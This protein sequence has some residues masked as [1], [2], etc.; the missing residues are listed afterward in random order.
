MNAQIIPPYLLTAIVVSP[1][2]YGYVGNL[3]PDTTAAPA[4]ALTTP[5]VP[6]TS[7]IDVRTLAPYGVPRLEAGCAQGSLSRECCPPNWG[8]A[9][10]YSPGMCPSAYHAYP[11][12]TSKQ[13]QET[14]NFCCPG[15]ETISTRRTQDYVQATP[16]QIRF[17]ASE[18]DIVPVPTSSLS[19]PR[20]WLRT[21]EKVG[22]GI[23]VAAGVGLISLALYYFFWVRRRGRKQIPQQAIPCIHEG[24]NADQVPPPP[25]AGN[26]NT[27][28][29]Q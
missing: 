21:R 29:K 22:I 16:I 20:D 28:T 14:T 23:G 19:L 8:D 2:A 9:V 17:R 26:A 12:P 18:S 11:L 15:D 25:Y 3:A 24:Q 7:C 4:G 1:S 13:R 6:P 27:S 5:F 10:Y